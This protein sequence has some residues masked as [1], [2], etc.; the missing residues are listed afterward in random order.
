LNRWQVADRL[1][2]SRDLVKPEGR[3]AESVCELFKGNRVE[4][5]EGFLSSCSEEDAFPMLRHTKPSSVDQ[6]I[7]TI[8][9][10]VSEIA[11]DQIGDI[12][13]LNREHPGDIF[14]DAQR[15]AK[16]SDVVQEALVEA[17]SWVI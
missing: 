10:D 1:P 11:D 4:V 16:E 3:A 7:C 9:S 12:P 17:V 6:A 13:L 14:H 8:V 2:H 5:Y 15:W